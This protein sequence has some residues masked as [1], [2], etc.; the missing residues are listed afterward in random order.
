MNSVT[1]KVQ[2]VY[3]HPYGNPNLKAE[4]IPG[5]PEAAAGEV[6]EVL[7]GVGAAL[8]ASGYAKPAPEKKPKP[9]E[10]EP[11]LDSNKEG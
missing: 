3:D 4:W 1:M 10:A 2:M 6:L 7:F 8:I 9:I 11:L 5:A